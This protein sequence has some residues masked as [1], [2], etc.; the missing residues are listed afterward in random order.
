M[1][2]NIVFLLAAVS[3]SAIMLGTPTAFAQ[4]TI[5]PAV[6]S[7]APGCEETADGCYIPSTATVDVGGVVI[8]TNTDSAAHTF[9]SGTPDGGPD[10]I[11]DTSLLMVDGSYEWSPDTV[12]EV[13][14]FCMVHP[15]MQ[16][17]IVVQEAGAQPATSAPYSLDDIIAEIQTS[18]GVA[19]EVMTIDLTLTDLDGNGV[20]HIT[21][22]IKALQD[23]QIV[24]DEEGHMHKG[25]LTNSHTTTPLSMDASDSMP[26]NITIES[27]G[28][29]HDE[30]Y[31]T[32]P[33]EITTKQVV[34]EFGTIAV[35]IM[36]VAITSVIVVSAK[37]R[38]SLMPKL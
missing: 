25:T 24:L 10:G 4:V 5:E 11:F 28:F 8:M 7:G 19:N 33:G 26:V 2:T 27:V 6:G 32:S 22:N 12:G 15:W 13:P 23:S 21:Y 14:Y 17:L 37:S 35:L 9:T 1:Q 34:P 31:V 18:D 36:V 20:E 29:G 3:V 16:G 38:L 30:L